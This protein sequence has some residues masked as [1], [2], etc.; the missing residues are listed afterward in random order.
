MAME[1]LV[2]MVSKQVAEQQQQQEAQVGFRFCCLFVR[3]TIQT[4]KQLPA[5][6]QFGLFDFSVTSPMAMWAPIQLIS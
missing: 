3:L 5:G 4:N 6:A 2:I 1:L